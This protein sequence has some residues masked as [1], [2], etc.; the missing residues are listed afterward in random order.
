MSLGTSAKSALPEAAYHLE[1]AKMK[2]IEKQD[3]ES[4]TD[5]RRVQADM[6]TCSQ[7][8]VLNQVISK[9][10]QPKNMPFSSP[11]GLCPRHGPWAAK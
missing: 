8:K 1:D 5:R 10:L 3:R 11:V 2:G 4:K 9:H 6:E 7:E